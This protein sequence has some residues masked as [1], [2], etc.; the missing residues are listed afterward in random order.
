MILDNQGNH[1]DSYNQFEIIKVPILQTSFWSGTFYLEQ[2]TI[3]RISKMYG[4]LA[5]VVTYIIPTHTGKP[6]INID[7]QNVHDDS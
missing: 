4:N 7:L 1:L 3:S 5:M 6:I 2:M